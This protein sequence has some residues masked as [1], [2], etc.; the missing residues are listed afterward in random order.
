MCHQVDPENPVLVAGDPERLH[1]QMCDNNGGIPYHR[2][3]ID[4]MV[5]GLLQT[6]LFKIRK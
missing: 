5:S 6:T 2:N 3:V 4:I 1:M